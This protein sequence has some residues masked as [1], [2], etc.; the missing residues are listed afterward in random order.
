MKY[1]LSWICRH[2]N[3]ENWQEIGEIEEIVKKISLHV[4]EVSSYTAITY[5]KFDIGIAKIINVTDDLCIAQY[6]NEEKI[7]NLPI[8]IDVEEG[9]SYIVIQNDQKKY[10]FATMKDFHSESKNHLLSPIQGEIDEN[11]RYLKA[12]Q[13]KKDY[14]LTIDSVSIGHRLDLFCHRGIAR[15]CAIL[16]KKS[17]TSE[18]AVYYDIPLFEEESNIKTTKKSKILIKNKSESIYSFAAV[19]VKLSEMPSLFEH[20]VLLSAIDVPSHSFLVDT[21]NYVLFDIG[22]PLHVFDKKKIETLSFVDSANGTFT[23]LDNTTIEIKP[24]TLVLENQENQI[25]SLVGIM[26]GQDTEVSLKTKEILI[27]SVAPRRNIIK[28]A[29]KE[30]GKKTESAIRMEKGVSP[31][32]PEFAIRAFLQIIKSYQSIHIYDAQS[33][34]YRND[35]EVNQPITLSKKY[36]IAIIGIDIEDTFI[37]EVLTKLGCIVH[38]KEDVFLVHVPWWRTRDLTNQD[39]LAEE[40]ARFF[41]YD[42]IPLTPPAVQCRSIKRNNFIH[43]LKE[44]TVILARAHEVVSYGIANEE[45]KKIWHINTA[46]EISLKNQYNDRYAKMTTTHLPDLLEIANKQMKLGINELSL[47]EINTIWEKNLEKYEEKMQYAF[48]GYGINKTTDF[49]YFKNILKQI[50]LNLGYNLK[51]QFTEINHSPYSDI[52]STIFVGQVL[53]GICGFIN[54]LLVYKNIKSSLLCFG[55]EIDLSLLTS[56]N[57]NILAEENFLSFDISFL[58]LKNHKIADLEKLLQIAFGYIAAIKVIDWFESTEWQTMRSVTLRIF[59]ITSDISDAYKEVKE[60]LKE[61]VCK[62]R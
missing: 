19:K 39:D 26:G 18:A 15:E 55:A 54:P 5:D 20:I 42:N 43:E 51:F 29:I 25:V 45:F 17:L 1:L 35:L 6:N 58:I 53:I 8:G 49:Y 41:G 7:I 50:F 10:R 16:F 21:S 34:F 27:E 13:A 60:Y 47:F 23:G 22:Q 30:H 33:E 61:R 57:K 52:K 32:A 9:F 3:I 56:L 36:V 59:V 48:L 44:Q 31:L 38:K 14:I 2:L 24:G 28:H 4:A 46:K 12:L 37:E 62:I 11:L 40:I